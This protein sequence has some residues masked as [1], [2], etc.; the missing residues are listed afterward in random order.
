MATK[1]GRKFL[2]TPGPT[3]VPDRV[4]NAMHQPTLDL[5]DP[6]F[7]DIS[8]SC[9]LDMR[10]VFNTEGEF[11]SVDNDFLMISTENVIAEK[12]SLPSIT[13]ITVPSKIPANISFIKGSC[14]GAGIALI[15]ISIMAYDDPLNLIAVPLVVPMG[16][17]LGGLASYIAPKFGKTKGYLIQN[18]EWK[19]VN[20]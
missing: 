10:K 13:K 3:H 17:F 1:R 14:Y 7:L 20:D 8:M 15:H 16:A 19:I 6:D 5:S 11:K 9:F 12:I 4:M 18:D 2:N